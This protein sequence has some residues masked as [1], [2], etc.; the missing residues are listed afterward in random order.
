MWRRYIFDTDFIESRLCVWHRAP[1]TDRGPSYWQL[2]D[3]GD[4]DVREYDAIV[5]GIAGWH[6]TGGAGLTLCEYL[7][8]VLGDL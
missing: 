1:C 3:A 7:N 5:T 2:N 4:I 6:A 8:I